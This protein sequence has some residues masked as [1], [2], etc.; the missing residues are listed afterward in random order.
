MSQTKRSVTLVHQE[1]AILYFGLALPTAQPAP[2]KVYEQYVDLGLASG[3]LPHPW[4]CTEAVRRFLEVQATNPNSTFWKSWTDVIERSQT[5]LFIHALVH[6]LTTYGTDYSMP[7][8]VPN[9]DYA[10]LPFEE[11]KPILPASEKELASRCLLQLQSGIALS[12]EN[13]EMMVDFIVTAAFNGDFEFD[14]DSVVNREAKVQLCR[15]LHIL[16][17]RPQELLRLLVWQLTSSSLL[18]KS[19]EA[20]GRISMAAA[21]ARGIIGAP[22]SLGHADLERLASIFYRF[23]PIFLAMRSN[24]LWRP[25]INR[26]RRMAR[27]LH[28]PMRPGVMESLLSPLYSEVEFASAIEREGNLW[29]LFRAYAY[30]AGERELASLSEDYRKAFHIRNGKVFSLQ[31]RPSKDSEVLRARAAKAGARAAAVRRRIVGIMSVFREASGKSSVL[32]PADIRLAV[33]VSE[34]QFVGDIPFGSSF[35]MADHNFVG[36]YWRNE[37]GTHDYDLSFIDVEGRRL[38]WNSAYKAYADG[39]VFSGDMTDA[40]PEATEM[41]YCRNA[42]PDGIFKLNRFNGS[43][44]SRA[45]IFF[46][47]QQIADLTV[48]F[49]VDPANIRFKADIFP[50]KDETVIGGIFANRA[51]IFSGES[52]SGRVSTNST[53]LLSLRRSMELRIPMRELL[54]EAGFTLASPEDFDFEAGEAPDFDFRSYTRDSLIGFY[55]DAMEA[56][57][58]GETPSGRV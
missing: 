4:C 43:R 38:A 54:V 58:E 19:P 41:F 47:R 17:S 7:A 32:L 22:D 23:R 27:A 15:E 12:A 28:R 30:L 50:E 48:G 42:M 9:R 13:V 16:P 57:G 8:Y 18:I 36:V 31:V 37:W 21:D 25:V 39:M 33:P 29:K 55:A 14:I 24:P 6:Y 45:R 53:D 34:K 2:D 46:G 56:S 35:P 5:E 3:Y 26:I 1:R 10:S 51:Y 49:M 52:A 11:L 40:D 20:L 44:G